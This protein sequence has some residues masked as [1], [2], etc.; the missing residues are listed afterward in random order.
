MFGRASGELESDLIWKLIYSATK[1]SDGKNVFHADHKN[2]ASSG[3]A[4]GV[5]PLSDARTALRRQTGLAGE[6][7]N[8]QFASLIV[9]PELETKAQ[10]LFSNDVQP[11]SANDVNIFKGAFNLIVESRLTDTKAW[12]LAANPANIDMLVHSYLDGQEGLFTES[13]YGFEVD[14]VQ[15]KVR[16]DFGC[17]ILDY[18]GFYKNPGA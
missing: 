17:G 13:R 16:K 4:L 6:T 8:L 18:R 11:T 12:Y 7:L 14:G 2:L 10:Q 3:A 1:M 9:P 15:I 5:T